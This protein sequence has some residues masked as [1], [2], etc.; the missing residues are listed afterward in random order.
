MLYYQI[1]QHYEKISRPKK[2]G[3]FD[4]VTLI[5]IL[6]ITNPSAT[7]SVSRVEKKNAATAIYTRSARTRTNHMPTCKTGHCSCTARDDNDPPP[8]HHRTLTSR[9]FPGQVRCPHVECGPCKKQAD[10]HTPVRTPCRPTYM[11]F[12]GT[13]D[14]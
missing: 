14:P 8:S 12:F 11:A 13:S 4:K 2:I 6:A 9:D 3:R 1:R 10:G 5:F 7:S